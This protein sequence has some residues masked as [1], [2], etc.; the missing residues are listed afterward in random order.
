M[1]A[2]ATPCRR[3]GGLCTAARRFVSAASTAPRKGHEVEVLGVPLAAC[4]AWAA[5]VAFLLWRVGVEVWHLTAAPPDS[6]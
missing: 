2:G 6:P 1:P 5:C 4:A 3:P